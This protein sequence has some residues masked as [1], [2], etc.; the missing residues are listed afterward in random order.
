M[1]SALG[2]SRI[3]EFIRVCDNLKAWIVNSYMVKALYMRRYVIGLFAKAAPAT[4][5]NCT[6]AIGRMPSHQIL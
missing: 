1:F 4:Q 3:L 5:G 2:L 6:D